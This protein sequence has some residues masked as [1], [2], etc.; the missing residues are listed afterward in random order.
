MG[1]RLT[2]RPE[3]AETWTTATAV[4]APASDPLE[5]IVL[6]ERQERTLLQLVACAAMATLLLALAGSVIGG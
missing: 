5:Q 1:L 6:A 2:L 3:F 4:S